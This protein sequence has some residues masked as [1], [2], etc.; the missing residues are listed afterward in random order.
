MQ[1][2]R[3]HIRVVTQEEQGSRGGRKCGAS[4]AFPS[5]PFHPA[6]CGIPEPLPW[7]TQV[8]H[9]PVRISDRDWLL[10]KQGPCHPPCP[11]PAPAASEVT[12]QSKSDGSHP[13]PPRW[14]GGGPG[15]PSPLS[16]LR[17][18]PAHPA[19]ET[20][21]TSTGRSRQAPVWPPRG[22]QATGSEVRPGGPRRAEGE[23]TTGAARAGTGGLVTHNP[24]AVPECQR[25]RTGGA[26]CAPPAAPRPLQAQLPG[27]GAH[28]E[29]EL[30]APIPSV[31]D[32]PPSESRAPLGAPQPHTQSFLQQTREPRSSY[33]RRA[34][35]ACAC[36]SARLTFR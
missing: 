26:I 2:S 13:A 16:Q 32:W 11:P 14:A 21:E 34:Q 27:H 22:L 30:C 9:T 36:G 19:F 8:S 12:A 7:A 15:H 33:P 5:L 6:A 4:G 20:L 35:R 3:L 18:G 17:S 10:L 28:K 31:D 25:D 23:L 24:T 1:T 29:A